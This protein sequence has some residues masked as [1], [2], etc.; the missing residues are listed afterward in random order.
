[1]IINFICCAQALLACLMLTGSW[2][3]NYDYYAV[4]LRTT[5][6][7]SDQIGTV[8]LAPSIRFPLFWVFWLHYP[9]ELSEEEVQKLRGAASFLNILE[10]RF[11]AGRPSSSRQSSR[12]RTRTTAL[13][14]TTP[15]PLDGTSVRRANT[16]SSDS[17]FT[18]EMLHGSG[19]LHYYDYYFFPINESLCSK[20]MDT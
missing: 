12:D 7:Q 14:S 6:V 11:N 4:H 18:G 5:N 3:F 19:Y 1:M 17:D 8:Y 16:A 20:A 10:Q 15:G 2:S 9:I 13:I